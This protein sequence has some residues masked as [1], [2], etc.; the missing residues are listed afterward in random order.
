[1]VLWGCRIGRR[2][3]RRHLVLWGCRIGRRLR[4][5]HLVLWGCRIGRGLWQCSRWSGGGCGRRRLVLWGCRFGRGLRRRKTRWRRGGPTRRRRRRCVRARVGASARWRGRSRARFRGY[6]RRCHLRPLLGSGCRLRCRVARGTLC[7]AFRRDAGPGGRR[8]RRFGWPRWSRRSGWLMGRRREAGR[9]RGAG[10]GESGRRWPRPS[11]NT[12]G[13]SGPT[14]GRLPVGLSHDPSCPAAVGT[15]GP[16]ASTRLWI[17]W[18][19]VVCGGSRICPAIASARYGSL[20]IAH[21]QVRG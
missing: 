15:S 3:R 10:A 12:R 18:R 4:R 7:R 8:L 6:S 9:R 14:S 2:L 13:P 11:R 17:G 20:R 19:F 21:E 16:L 5:R 1:M